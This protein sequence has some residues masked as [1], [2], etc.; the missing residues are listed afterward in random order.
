MN[1][2]LSAT[3]DTGHQKRTN[4]LVLPGFQLRF[5]MYII[6]F[7]LFGIIVLY[8][9]NHIYFQR[10]IGQGQQLGLAPD[11]VYF[12]FVNQQREVLNATFVLVA[13][14]VLG[15]LVLVGLV[16]SHKI[17]GPIYRIQ[18]H[19]REVREQG[20]SSTPLAFRDGDFFP[21]VAE[22]VDELV[23]RA[24]QPDKPRPD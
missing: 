1:R 17:A 21:E 6:G 11:H 4:F 9:S 10:L 2:E 13:A 23:S 14:L 18:L 22:L 15:G 19:L 12:E 24:G 16:L 5:M 8:A 20:A 3:P 7:A